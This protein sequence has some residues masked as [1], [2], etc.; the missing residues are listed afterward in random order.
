M[1]TAQQ[2]IIPNL[3]FDH[4]HVEEAAMF[5]LAAFDNAKVGSITR[6][7]NVGYDITGIRAGEVVTVE[8]EIEGHKFIGING[9]PSSNST[10][11]YLS[12]LPARQKTRSTGYWINWPPAVSP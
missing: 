5:Y 9:G 8:L 7:G 10:R 1:P 4:G 2:K 3:W 11:R 6:A 12:S